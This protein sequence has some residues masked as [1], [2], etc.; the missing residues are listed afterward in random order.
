MS[1]RA[2]SCRPS[3]SSSPITGSTSQM[4]DTYRFSLNAL[5]KAAVTRA[6]ASI[7]PG[8]SGVIRMAISPVVKAASVTTSSGLSRTMKPTTTTAMPISVQ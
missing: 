5:P 3:R 6:S 1:W 2:R 4:I 7:G 8:A